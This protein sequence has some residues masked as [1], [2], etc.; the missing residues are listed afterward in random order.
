MS[1]GSEVQL[2]V[3]I[4]A[5]GFNTSF[6]PPFRLIGED[7]AVLNDVWKEAPRAYLGLAAA[8][9]PNY[10]SM[11]NQSCA[12]IKNHT[13]DLMNV[14]STGP[15]APAAHGTFIACIEAYLNYAFTAVER[16]MTENIKSIAPKEEAVDDFQEHK[17]DIVQD[18]VWT[19]S[20]RSWYV[21]PMTTFAR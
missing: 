6:C 8:K 15:N 16:L 2:D 13:A 12:L 18:L 20:C 3:L 4:C 19:S 10:F 14:V 17:D 5:T 21:K 11:L 9:F 7:G 1:D